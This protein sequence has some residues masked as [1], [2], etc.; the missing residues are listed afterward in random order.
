MADPVEDIEDGS[1]GG[2][3]GGEWRH[4]ETPVLTQ[5]PTQSASVVTSFLKSE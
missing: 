1:A 2:Y 4:Q 3:S 5:V